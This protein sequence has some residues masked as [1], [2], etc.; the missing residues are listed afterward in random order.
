[1][2]A[3]TR[4]KADA[5]RIAQTRVR[6]LRQDTDDACDGGEEGHAERDRGNPSVPRRTRETV[7]THLLL[8]R[9]GLLLH[10][11]TR[12]LAGV[13]ERLGWTLLSSTWQFGVLAG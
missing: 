13:I 8:E 6:G 3:R 9:L 7:M 4:A 12:V 10:L 5:G 11:D 1:D 2:H